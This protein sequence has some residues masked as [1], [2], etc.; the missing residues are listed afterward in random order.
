V[1]VE[2]HRVG[3]SEYQLRENGRSV[4][5]AGYEV[6]VENKAEIQWAGHPGHEPIFD[7][8]GKEDYTTNQGIWIGNTCYGIEVEAL[9]PR[10]YVPYLIDALVEA[11]GGDEELRE[12]LVR[13]ANPDFSK[14][15]GMIVNHGKGFSKLYMLF[16]ALDNWAYSKMNHWSGEIEAIVD[17]MVGEPITDDDDD[18]AKEAKADDWCNQEDVLKAAAE[19]VKEKSEG[20]DWKAFKDYVTT[21]WS[22]GKWSP[23]SSEQANLALYELFIDQK[24]EEFI[25]KVQKLDDD[26][27]ETLDR[28]RD[29]FLRH[30]GSK[31]DGLERVYFG[32]D[33]QDDDKD[34]DFWGT[35]YWTVD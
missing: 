17:E 9:E 7:L 18:E 11:A 27:Q 19:V 3:V 16:D 20:I 30:E 8:F 5:Q 6:K 29:T 10:M 15:K 31:N 34:R 24:G 4:V 32:G 21:S 12:K 13:A 33:D 22:R 14:V 26:N 28:L 2:L 23:V 35:Y 25:E 1:P